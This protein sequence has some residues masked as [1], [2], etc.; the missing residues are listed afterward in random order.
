MLDFWIYFDMKSDESS[1]MKELEKTFRV[2]RKTNAAIEIKENILE[3]WKN[4][5]FD[6]R[7][8]K[9]L[10]QYRYFIKSIFMGKSVNIS[11]QTSIVK[12]LEEYFTRN[13]IRY[14]LLKDF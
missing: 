11:D 7:S 13:K 10:H 1:I 3:L 14:T 6:P 12:R 8:K 2:K 5:S 4:E 9:E